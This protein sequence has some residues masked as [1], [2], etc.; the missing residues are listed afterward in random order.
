[1][2]PLGLGL[3]NFD[4]I[5]RWRDKDG[6]LP[7]DASSQLAS[8]ESFSGVRELRAILAEKRRLFYRC[9]T[10]KLMTYALGRGIEYTDTLTIESIVD[11]MM[12]GA[13]PAEQG[14]FT[15]LLYSILESPQFQ[16]RRGNGPSDD[17]RP[18]AS[19]VNIEKD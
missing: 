8:G 13:E 3:E 5:G 10:R 17:L 9:L 4:A 18:V 16:M 14:R 15:T 19:A 7:I 6:G 2:D 11:A 12:V 1:M